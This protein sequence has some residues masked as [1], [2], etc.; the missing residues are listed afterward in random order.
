MSL[1]TSLLYHQKSNCLVRLNFF[2]LAVVSHEIAISLNLFL[3]IAFYLWIT[4]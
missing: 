3:G 1:K 2:E 4:I